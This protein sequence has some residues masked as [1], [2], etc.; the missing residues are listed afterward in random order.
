MLQLQKLIYKKLRLIERRML[1]FGV[2]PPH[3]GAE[4]QP[5]NDQLVNYFCPILQDTAITPV[6]VIASG[7]VFSQ[8][9]DLQSI[10]QYVETRAGPVRCPMT[11][12]IWEGP[13]IY[14]YNQE[15]ARQIER[16]LP[17]YTRP[18]PQAEPAPPAEPEA[19]PE[20]EFKPSFAHAYV[21]W[22]GLCG[23]YADARAWLSS[24][25]LAAITNYVCDVVTK[26]V[27]TYKPI[28]VLAAVTFTVTAVWMYSTS[29]PTTP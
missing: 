23:A 26:V 28:V 2:S 24:I 7:R 11:R 27:L 18:M 13:I 17:G 5:D 10:K 3:A 6:Q 16:V 9:Y 1:E 8:I 29:R 22:R 25:D 14:A 20:P 19:E 12:A 21:F 15:A 4:A